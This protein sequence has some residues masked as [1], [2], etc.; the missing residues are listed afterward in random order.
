MPLDGCIYTLTVGSALATNLSQINL[1]QLLFRVTLKVRLDFES[2]SEQKTI[3]ASFVHN[4]SQSQAR[5]IFVT[6]P[7]MDNSDCTKMNAHFEKFTAWL[8]EGLIHG[9]K[10]ALSAPPLPL[11][12]L[13]NS[14]LS[15]TH[16]HR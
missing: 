11:M 1:C 3:Y 4:Y 10:Q 6:T 16:S 9:W 5:L 2:S 12:S 8:R 7:E 15:S 14:R 13:N